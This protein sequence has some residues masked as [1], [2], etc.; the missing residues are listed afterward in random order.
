MSLFGWFRREDGSRLNVSL[1]MDMARELEFCLRGQLDELE[2]LGVRVCINEITA[3]YILNLLTVSRKSGVNPTDACAAAKAAFP[4]TEENR[5]L[6]DGAFVILASD[7][8]AR[9]K[10]AVLFSLAQT[11]ISTGQ[12]EFLVRHS[13]KAEKAIAAMFEPKPR[14]DLREEPAWSPEDL[15]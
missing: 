9:S 6:I 13:R 1:Q 4:H 5:A 11:E 15:A 7:V 2:R 10:L 14:R 12:Y 3:A 8:Q